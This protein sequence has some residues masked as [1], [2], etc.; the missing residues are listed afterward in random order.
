MENFSR[1]IIDLITEDWNDNEQLVMDALFYL[2]KTSNDDKMRAQIRDIFNE[3]D[4]CL[5]CGEK[6]ETRTI[7]E[8]HDELDER[9]VEYFTEMYCPNCDR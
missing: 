8:I 7:K 6:L 3:Y 1:E 2:Y 4:Y 9:T 5:S